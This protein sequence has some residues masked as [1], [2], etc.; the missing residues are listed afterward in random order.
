MQPRDGRGADRNHNLRPVST[1]TI[2]SLIPQMLGKAE[3]DKHFN[4]IL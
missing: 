3:P 1:S 2:W 4:K